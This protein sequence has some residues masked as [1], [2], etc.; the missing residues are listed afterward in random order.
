MADRWSCRLPLPMVGGSP[1]WSRSPGTQPGR[2]KTR[3]EGWIKQA[4]PLAELCGITVPTA[5][6]AHTWRATPSRRA[7]SRMIGLM[8]SHRESTGASGYG[9]AGRS[10]PEYVCPVPAPQYVRSAGHARLGSENEALHRTLSIPA[11]EAEAC[12]SGRSRGTERAR[13]LRLARVA[14][15]LRQNYNRCDRTGVSSGVKPSG[16][17]PWQR[18]QTGARHGHRGRGPLPSLP[19]GGGAVRRAGG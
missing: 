1:A 11:T 15:A 9:A 14:A 4:P 2:K 12:G 5:A 3:Q 17:G 6:A 8:A 18:V 19:T 10:Q 16:P 13:T 7:V